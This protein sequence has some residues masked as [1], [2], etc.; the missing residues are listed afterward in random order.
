MSTTEPEQSPHSY[1]KRRGAF[2]SV[3]HGDTPFKIRREFWRDDKGNPS[4]LYYRIDDG[5][6]AEPL[7]YLVCAFK[8]G[9]FHDEAITPLIRK[10]MEE[11]RPLTDAEVN[12][13]V[14]PFVLADQ[15]LVRSAE[16]MKPAFAPA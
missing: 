2:S 9:R 7:V 8:T 12:E 10:A 5:S 6:D 14:D 11:E 16:K 3:R 1:L 4:A 13:I 15:L